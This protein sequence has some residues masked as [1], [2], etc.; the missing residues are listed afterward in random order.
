MTDALT[1]ARDL[2]TGWQDQHDEALRVGAVEDHYQHV[3]PPGLIRMWETGDNP[4]G[5]PLSP[6]EW[7]AMCAAWF[8]TFGELPPSRDDSQPSDPTPE[9]PPADDT[10][11]DMHQVVRMTGLSE[12]TLKRRWAAGTF[13]RPI[14]L[15]TRRMG[16]LSSSIKAWLADCERASDKGRY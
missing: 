3:S 11:L 5:E 2:A 7:Q 15:S 10:M 16:W 8:L 1:R 9:P 4:E 12:S 14:K 13:P 6:F